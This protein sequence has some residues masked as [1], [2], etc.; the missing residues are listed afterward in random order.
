M[1]LRP[2]IKALQRVIGWLSDAV[3]YIARGGWKPLLLGMVLTGAALSAGG[4][5]FA[6]SG[7][8]PISASSGHWPITE[9]FLQFSMH[10]AV[11]THAI[12]VE[13]PPL[14]DPALVLKGAGH[15]A[16]GCAPCHGA[17]GEARSLIALQMT[18]K[19]PFLP[20]QVQDWTHEQLFWIIKHGIK[21]TAMPAWVSLERDDEV[22]AMVA[23]VAELPVL[24][25]DHY[26][27]L[28][29]GD[30][31]HGTIAQ[32]RDPS[33]L[34][35]IVDPLGPVLANCARCHGVDGRGRGLGAFPVL[36]NQ[37]ETY[38]WASLKAYAKG[39][40]NS[41]IMQPI[42]ANL[43][44]ETMRALAEHYANLD[45]P[46][47]RP[48]RAAMG[49][50]LVEKPDGAVVATSGTQATAH[51]QAI[52]QKGIPAKGVP[53]CIHCHGPRKGPRNPYYPKIAGQYADYLALQLALFK[54]GQRGGT[55]YAHIM[56]AVAEELTE[57]QIGDLALYYS[58]LEPETGDTQEHPG[59]K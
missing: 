27:Q 3:V 30:A 26:R 56:H 46:A 55:P 25:P 17:P 22:W 57:D 23:F 24:S 4:L 38:L 20:L 31:R 58:S 9:R 28:A 11:E 45:P 42:A 51:G 49:N 53:S 5:L 19:P 54:T 16:T 33:P 29:Y 2:A 47:G 1:L 41:G 12:G 18:P 37:S 40:R 44:D 48:K 15:Y 14:S 7:L 10:Q 59:Q 8:V 32:E 36:A 50:D 21:A 43:S 39:Q 13:K 34:Q 35:S 6:W 52:A